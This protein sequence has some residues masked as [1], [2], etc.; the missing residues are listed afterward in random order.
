MKVG[1]NEPCPCGSGKKQK[2]CCLSATHLDAVRKEKEAKRVEQREK[3]KTERKKNPGKTANINS[4]MMMLA[5]A[6]M[7]GDGHRDRRDRRKDDEIIDV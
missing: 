1:R 7:A 5:M 4:A 2:K 3:I 6:A